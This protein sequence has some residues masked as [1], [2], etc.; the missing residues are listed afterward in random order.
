MDTAP[1][2]I[3]PHERRAWFC[4]LFR[5]YSR[6]L[7]RQGF[8]AMRLASGGERA[9]AAFDAHEGPTILLLNHQSWWDPILT[10]ALVD[11]FTPGRHVYAPMDRA[12]VEQFAFMRKLG[13]FGV[14]LDQPDA[15]KAM[16]QYASHLA[17]TSPCPS[18]WIT[19]Q[20]EFADPRAPLELRPG[21]AA[22]ASRLCRDGRPPRVLCLAIELT[23]WQDRKPEVLLLARA[24]PSPERATMSL[25]QREMTGTLANAMRELSELAI[26]RDPSAFEVVLGRGASG[27]N[28]V[29]DTFLRLTGRQP[30]ISARRPRS[31][32]TP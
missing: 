5:W 2:A 25:W 20:G 4:R 17:A 9:F 23:F 19:P 15:F 28:P 31:D 26:A 7:V 27:V 30:N 11:C 24:C 21:A 18:F 1:S 32:A 22:I 8:N 29:Y 12:M 6:R 13:L 10:I 16:V 14:D 3:I